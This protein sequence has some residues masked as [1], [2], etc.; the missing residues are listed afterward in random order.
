MQLE[1]ME[2]TRD[3]YTSSLAV[4]SFEPPTLNP[5]PQH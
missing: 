5:R 1:T 3:G 2:A 4:N